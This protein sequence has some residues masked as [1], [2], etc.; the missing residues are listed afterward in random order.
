ME[1]PL[2]ALG[3]FASGALEGARGMTTPLDAAAVLPFGGV[4]RALGKTAAPMRRTMQ[5]F[6]VVDD[7]PTPQIQP[8]QGEVTDLLWDLQ[9]RLGG[10]PQA[11]GQMRRPSTQAGSPMAG[12]RSA[13]PRSTIAPSPEFVPRGG[14]A[15]YNAGRPAAALNE[16][17]PTGGFDPSEFMMRQQEARRRA[18]VS[19]MIP[20]ERR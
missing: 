15:A 4:A 13:A 2:E 16:G 20:G 19:Q 12:L 10:I 17:L 14:E 1:N 3:G 11:T 7:I 9:N 8:G 6:D 5:A 18:P